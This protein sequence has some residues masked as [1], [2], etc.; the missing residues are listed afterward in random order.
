MATRWAWIPALLAAALAGAGVVFAGPAP[1]SPTAGM[2]VG[3]DSSVCTA[4]FAVQDRFGDYYL[5]TSGHCDAGDGSEWTDAAAAPLGPIFASEN[6]GDDR[7][8]AIIRLRPGTPA[9]NGG[10]DGRYHIRDVLRPDQIQVGMPFCKVG[11]QTG[12]TCGVVTEV[13][14]NV[15]VT[16]LYSI[17]GDSGSPGFVTNPDGS[18]SAAGILMGGPEDDDNITYFVM[19]EPLLR[20]WRMQIL[21]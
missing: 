11:S 6:N 15:V 10:V 1:A 12:E 4:G 18:V 13:A 7:D 17:E 19:V 21:K 5:L 2:E 3:D 16:D 8:A 9:P 14:G 20:Q